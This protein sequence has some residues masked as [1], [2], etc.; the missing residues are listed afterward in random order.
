LAFIADGDAWV[1]ETNGC[2]A[3]GAGPGPG[4]RVTRDADAR[5]IAWT[6]D[7]EALLISGTW[8]EER[9]ELRRMDMDG[10]TAQSTRIMVIGEHKGEGTFG[11]SRDGRF[12][13]SIDADTRGDVWVAR[14]VDV[15]H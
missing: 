3:A 14:V 4:S 5:D 9:L 15:L 2:S 7:G 1:A 12:V 11:V 6:A 13:A 10:T 8:G